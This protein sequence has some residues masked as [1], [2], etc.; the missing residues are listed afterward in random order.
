MHERMHERMHDEKKLIDLINH[1]IPSGRL[2]TS[3]CYTSDAEILSLGNDQLLFN[4]DDFSSEDLLREHDPYLLGWNVAVGGISDILASGGYPLF[5]GHSM[6]IG[7][8]WE[9]A[10][11]EKFCMG[12]RDVL[13][14]SGAEFMG[15]DLSKAD[16]WRY[17]TAVI[18]KPY[19]QPVKRTGA[20]VGDILF[21]SGEIGLGNFEALLT[22]LSKGGSG[23]AAEST[24][25]AGPAAASSAAESLEAAS[26]E[27]ASSAAQPHN[28]ADNP[29]GKNPF[30]TLAATF[31]NQF[32]IPMQAAKL[33]SEFATACTDTSDGLFN[34]LTTLCDMNQLGYEISDLPY[35]KRGM[36][37]IALD[38][39]KSLG[40]PKSLMFL[41]ECGEFELLF[42]VPAAGEGHFLAAAKAT[43]ATFYRLGRMTAADE[44]MSKVLLQD[45][46]R[47]ALQDMTI[48]ARDF[49]DVQVYLFTLLQWAQ[50][51]GLT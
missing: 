33:V 12:V 11:I 5:Y 20:A 21:I 36:E 8:T 26:L 46:K 4:M 24:A 48:R 18:G 41:G 15:G 51:K 17:T 27:A 35:F 30:A 38:P 32:N 7:D 44:S 9:T 31:V 14:K 10:Y 22:L 43:G 19:H 16:K 42:T 39:I 47:F 6:V 29:L 13:Q 23:D 3:R 28:A 2:R 50:E 40:L 37:L 34:S 49:E 45:G 1:T 25:G